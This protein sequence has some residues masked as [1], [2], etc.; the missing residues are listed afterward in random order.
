MEKGI[1]GVVL[2]GGKGCRF[3]GDKARARFEGETLLERTVARLA[4]VFSEVIVVADREDRFRDLSVRCVVDR[5]PGLGPI[6]GIDAALRA[7]SGRA[8]FVVAC[9][10]PFLNPEVIRWMVSLS[11]G[12][13]LVIPALSDG[14]HPLHALYT[15][16]SLSAIAAQI[17][18]GERALC[19]LAEYVRS[20][21]VLE[22]AFR[23]RDPSLLSVMNIN[24]PEDFKQASQILAKK[25]LR[26]R[27]R[28]R[29]N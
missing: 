8:I 18:K 27:L 29:W 7:A 22:E 17:E 9:D 16:R 6:G 20:R 23:R 12:Y 25:E 15:G 3:G 28:R 1:L 24:R 2:A 5:L 11:Q 10:M 26:R 19:S 4:L 21:F 13:D 14:L